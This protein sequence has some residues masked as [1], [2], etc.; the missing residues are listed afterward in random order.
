[1]L[2]DEPVHTTPVRHAMQF[3]RHYAPAMFLSLMAIMIG[4]AVVAVLV[5]ILQP[6]RYITSQ[7][8][9]LDFEGASRGFYPNGLKFSP[10]DIVS[11]PI[12]L[13]VFND[14]KVSDF[15]T[16]DQFSKSIFVLEANRQYE[17]LAREYGS[18]LA[19]PKLTPVDRERL[20]REYEQ[21]RSSIDKSVY[22]LSFVRTAD[23]ERVP[24]TVIKKVLTDTLALWAQQA[25]V[26]KHVLQYQV[27]VLTTAILDRK[28]MEEVD[29]IVA[30]TILRT[31]VIDLRINV[32]QISHMPGVELVRTKDQFSLAEVREELDDLV[33]YRIEPLIVAARSTGVA[34][35]PVNSARML[36]AQLLFDQGALDSAKRRQSALREALAAYEQDTVTRALLAA[37]QSAATGSGQH[38]GSETVM[39]QISETFLDRIVDL[40]N[41]N[42]DREYRQKMV[43]DIK[44]ASLRI[45]PLEEAVTYD[46]I[47]LSAL[48]AAKATNPTQEAQAQ[49]ASR[50]N[51]AYNAVGKAIGHINEI[52]AEAQRNL[53]PVTQLF[54][55][56]GPPIAYTE[57]ATSLARL[58]LYGILVFLV[59]LPLVVGAAILHNRA[60]E[61]EEE[62]RVDA[63]EHA[64]ASTA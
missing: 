62:E 11:T 32:E 24:P 44:M 34:R 9:R 47:T 3:V 53:N 51:E 12:L 41:R 25:A 14:N 64:A 61:E 48:K 55:S 60:R 18:K 43:D 37:K 52:Y 50:W 27:P 46:Q 21:K 23:T 1:M 19:D 10:A 17:A 49:M 15:T 31:K 54:S 8:F 28:F 45:V 39:P 6:S 20:E 63:T 56:N 7:S 30:L 2:V 38:T 26:E 58:A 57:R 59:S 29:Y 36:E 22:A 5:Y 13:R 35:D 16:F 33:R 40:T 42:A 4:Y